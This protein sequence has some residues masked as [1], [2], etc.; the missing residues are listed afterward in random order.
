[1]LINV[2]KIAHRD[3]P[4]G[5]NLVVIRFDTLRDASFAK[6]VGGIRT[7]AG[8]LCQA[9]ICRRRSFLVLFLRSE[10]QIVDL[11]HQRIGQLRIG[12]EVTGKPVRQPLAQRL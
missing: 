5:S 12:Y 6:L 2:I 8:Q 3:D 10:K 4:F 11:L 1:M 9:F 7:H